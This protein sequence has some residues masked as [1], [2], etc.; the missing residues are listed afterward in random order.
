ML[1]FF[2]INRGLDIFSC[3]L[4]LENPELPQLAACK[5]VCMYCNFQFTKGKEL[6]H[7]PHRYVN[8]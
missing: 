6:K 3:S 2:S 5:Y 4:I 1:L 8:S 7:R